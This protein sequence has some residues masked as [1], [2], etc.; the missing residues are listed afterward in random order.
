VSDVPTD[1]ERL[2]FRPVIKLARLIESRRVT[3][4]ALTRMYLARLKRFDPVLRCVVTLT[5]ELALRQA[6]RADDEIAA[7]RHRG[8]LHG[9]PWGVKD[10]FAARGYPTTW[11]APV[12]RNRILDLDATV[13]ER[14]D[15]AG[16]VLVAKLSLG[17]LARGDEW[18]GGMTRNP[19]NTEQG[20]GGS[21]AGS[22]ASVAAGLVGFSVG[23][24]TLDSII[25]PSARCGVTGLRPTYG[26][27]SRHGAMALS[28]SLD[29][30]GPICRT[31]EDCAAVL[32]ALAGP[33]GKDV[34][35]SNLPFNWDA[36]LDIRDV[37][38][39]YVRPAAADTKPSRRT[40]DEATLEVLRSLGLQPTLVELPELPP[41]ALLVMHAEAAA[42]FDELVQGHRDDEL[43]GLIGA[44]WPVPLRQSLLISAVDYLRANRVR[45]LLMQSMARLMSSID[46]YVV[47]TGGIHNSFLTNLTG[48]PC[49]TVPNGLVDGLPTAVSF[50][51]RLFEEAKLLAV[52]RAYQEATDFHRRFPPAFEA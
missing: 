37:R 42:A 19:W 14:L 10:L 20:S 8:L 44:A 50:V 16:A 1:I 23:S 40:N 24:S 36:A 7:G 32:D 47:P 31:V 15:Q 48:H 12:Y 46:V 41:A 6:R 45:T 21:S 26:R 39:G 25:G 34:T 2:A 28:W 35:V 9:I 3:S 4:V 51:G 33:D 17:P 29:K 49:I 52:A 18:Y 5:E 22:A 30:V 11:G 38:L 27:I 43:Q 13:V